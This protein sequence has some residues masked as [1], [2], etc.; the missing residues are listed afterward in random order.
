MTLAAYVLGLGVWTPELP[1]VSTW[2][3]GTPRPALAR[4]AAQLLP[5]RMRGRA[6]LLTAMF[7]EVVEQATRAAGVEAQRLPGVFGSAYGEMGTTLTLLSQLQAA[8]AQLSPA[9]FQASVHNTAAG[10]LSIALSNPHFSTSLAAGHDTLAMCLLEGCA[11]LA[12]QPG[13]LLLAVAEEGASAVLQP[14]AAY[15]PL[16]AA[17]VLASDAPPGAALARVHAPEVCEHEPR[18]ERARDNPL[19]PALSLA[20]AVLSGERVDV[21]VNEAGAFGHTIHVQSYRRSP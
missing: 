3:A 14:E 2:L 1:D 18:R 8:G 15:A 12:Q 5:P 19:L 10:Q 11:F 6:S 4:P 21:P 17:F 20:R 13:Q 7:A 16:A 9:K